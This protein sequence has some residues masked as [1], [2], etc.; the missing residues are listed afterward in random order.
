MKHKFNLSQFSKVTANEGLPHEAYVVGVSNT[1]L[2]PRGILPVYFHNKKDCLVLEVAAKETGLIGLVQTKSK[3]LDQ[4]WSEVRYQEQGP[5]VFKVG[6]LG[7]I[8]SAHY[9]EEGLFVLIRGLCRFRLEVDSLSGAPELYAI[10]TESFQGDI[11]EE[12]EDA[13]SS[14]REYLQMLMAQIIA[15]NEDAQQIMGELLSSSDE[16]LI[17]TLAMAGPFSVGEKQALIEASD[18]NEQASLIAK[19]IEMSPKNVA[20]AT[21]H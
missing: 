8:L 5:H 15:K 3:N 20:S 11:S 4:L 2:L 13:V 18:L 7:E 1:L 21:Q 10:N 12:S 14:N 9:D 6:C 17:T 16:K 19:M